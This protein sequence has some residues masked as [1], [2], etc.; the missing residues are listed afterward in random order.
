M[1]YLKKSLQSVKPKP[2][3]TDPQSAKAIKKQSSIK[4]KKTNK[5]AEGKKESERDRDRLK[6]GN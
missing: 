5:K 1:V 4:K 6:K 3:L 2:E